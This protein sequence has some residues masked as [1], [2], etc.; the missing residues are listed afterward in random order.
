MVSSSIKQESVLA[1]FTPTQLEV[2]DQLLAVGAARPT[3]PADLPAQL[4]DLIVSSTSE[5]TTLW[6]EP[7]L[8]LSKSKIEAAL[9]CEGQ[10]IADASTERSSLIH[11]ATAVGIVTHKAIQLANTHPN[12]PVGSYVD[13]AVK[14]A[15]TE[16]AFNEFWNAADMAVQSDLLGQMISKTTSFLDSFPPLSS[17]WTPRFEESIQAKLGKL[18]LAAKP[19]FILGRPRADLTQNMFLA[20]MKTGSLNESHQD[21]AMY[22]A[23]VSTLRHGVAPFRSVVYSLASGDWTDPDVTPERLF[24]AAERVIAAANAVAAVLTDRRQP[25]LSP[26]RWCSWCPARQSCPAASAV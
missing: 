10:L 5:A 8:W 20:D 14:A 6:T 15:L 4:R 19:D 25:V 12:R 11:P 26:G 13:A 18:V 23:L 9:R 7:K 21:E 22:Y 3:M 1:S 17:S 24:A 16:P 2:F